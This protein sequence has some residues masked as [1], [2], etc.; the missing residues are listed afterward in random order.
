MVSWK[1]RE[2]QPGGEGEWGTAARAV[3]SQRLP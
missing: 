2:W 3:E 1:P